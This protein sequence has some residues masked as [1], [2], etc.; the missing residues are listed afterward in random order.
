MKKLLALFICILLMLSTSA[1]KIFETELDDNSSQDNQLQ[2]VFE[3][4]IELDSNLLRAL[5]GTNDITEIESLKIIYDNNSKEAV[6][7]DIKDWEFLKK[8]VDVDTVSYSEKEKLIASPKTSLLVIGRSEGTIYLLN[9]G[10]IIIQVMCGDSEVKEEDRNFDIYKAEEKYML[11]ESK[12]TELLKKYKSSSVKT[13]T[14]K[15]SSKDDKNTSSNKEKPTS[16]DKSSNKKEP[17][18]Q[19]QSALIKS[20]LPKLNLLA[21]NSKVTFK[22]I[23]NLPNG[24]FAVVGH[25]STEND[26]VSIIQIYDKNSNFVKEYS[27]NY[28][29]GFDKI[30]ACSDG[31]FIVSSDDQL[32]VTKINSKFEKEWQTA[33]EDTTLSANVKDIEE[34]N[35]NCYAVLFVASPLPNGMLKVSFLDK[36]GKLIEKVDIANHIEPADADIIPDGSGGFYL[37]ST[38]DEFLAKKYPLVAK[39]YKKSK[40]TEVAVMRFSADRKLN[41]AKVFGGGGKDWVEDAAI[42]TK[43]NIYI[44][45]ATNWDSADS[46]WEMN[47][48]AYAPYRRMLVKLDKKGNIVYKAPLS[49]KGMPVDQVF[50]IHIQGT[51]AYVIGM[52][53]YFDGYQDKYLCEQI[54][55]SDINERIFSTYSA[56]FDS[57]GK[58]LGRDLF[59]CDTNNIP[60]DSILLPNGSIVV[61]GS[62]S[63]EDNHF[64]LKLPLVLDKIAALFVFKGM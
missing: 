60:C 41:W 20:R 59:R 48:D 56:C 2:A 19:N 40:D 16:S 6:I 12:L 18:K 17:A 62:V 54:P 61:A 43:G 10:R 8:Y 63:A 25:K 35:P 21:E 29:S 23:A 5:R 55:T 28:P 32:N 58:E 64:N 11:S 3:S 4:E 34:I 13:D 45:V 14:D 57:K 49:N 37:V 1:C 27:Y 7:T 31:G 44:A 42:D 51:K 53:E 30:A 38:C 9:D 46:F 50:G 36:A 26:S 52:S 47:V 22:D 33:F 15:T 24:G 39:N